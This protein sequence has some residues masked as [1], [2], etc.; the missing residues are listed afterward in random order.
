MKDTQHFHDFLIG[1][2]N[3]EPKDILQ[4]NK[5]IDKLITMIQPT[6]T[7][8]IPAPWLVFDYILHKYAQLKKIGKLEIEIC[9]YIAKK[10][11]IK[12]DEIECVL[13]FLHHNAGTVLYYR[14]IPELKKF[15][16]IYF[17]PIID[18]ISSIIIDHFHDNSKHEGHNSTN[19]LL[20]ITSVTKI[21]GYLEADELLSF[22]KHRHIISQLNEGE[23]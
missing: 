11:G 19:G 18:S 14:D 13:L 16:F 23:D 3:F 9:H 8:G 1:I 12:D 7:Q 5:K 20:K 22:M 6:D 10:C 21:E 15:V 4:V 2:D 17:Q